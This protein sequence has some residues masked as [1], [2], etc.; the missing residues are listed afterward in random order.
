VTAPIIVGGNGHS[1]TRLFAEILMACGVYMGIPGYS[2]DRNSKDLNIRSLMNRWMRP[3]LLG[4][5]ARQASTMAGQFRRRLRLLIPFRPDNWG[6]KNPRTMFLLPF[7]HAM[8][9]QMKFIHVIRD[10]RDMCFGNPFIESPTYWGVMTDEEASALTPEERMMR[11]W[12]E[13]NR[14]VKEYG[15]ANFGSRYLLIRFED[16]CNEP[17][18]EIRKIVELIGMATKP[19]E[20]LASLVRKPKSIGRWKDFPAKD[21]DKV[22]SIGESY[23]REF[24]YSA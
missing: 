14:K 13:G 1:G 19:P 4:L 22:V 11:F 18:T 6:F 16:I 5:D 7:Y 20:N 15:E 21:V 24:G 12:G 23:L 2:Y 10:G 9:P 8:F 3:Y 17:G